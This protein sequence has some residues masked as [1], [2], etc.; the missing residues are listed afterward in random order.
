[1]TELQILPDLMA[2]VEPGS[3]TPLIV[4]LGV[5]STAFWGAWFIVQEFRKYPKAV[6][7]ADRIAS[8]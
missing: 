2:K 5:L 6:K 8:E 7:R 3:L 4:T 1:M